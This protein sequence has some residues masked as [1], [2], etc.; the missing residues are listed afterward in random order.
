M[1]AAFLVARRCAWSPSFHCFIESVA[2]LANKND[3]HYVS[4][5]L[6]HSTG[7]HGPTFFGP[8]RLQPTLKP[9]SLQGIAVEET[10]GKRLKLKLIRRIQ[11]FTH[12]QSANIETVR[13]G[14]AI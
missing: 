4:Q 2:Q 5:M 13:K 14:Y 3:Y 8:A 11:T 6:L 9:I 7:L 10:G 1:S 12:I